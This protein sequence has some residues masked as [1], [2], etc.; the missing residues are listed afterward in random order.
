VMLNVTII[1]A[2]ETIMVKND[3]L[4]STIQNGL[5]YTFFK[6]STFIT[7]PIEFM[8]QTYEKFGFNNPSMLGNYSVMNDSIYLFPRL[9]QLYL[10]EDYFVEMEY[11][12]S[13]TSKFVLIGQMSYTDPQTGFSLL[14]EICFDEF[15]FLIHRKT[16]PGIEISLTLNQIRFRIPFISNQVFQINTNQ[17]VKSILFSANVQEYLPYSEKSKYSYI[18]FLNSR[19]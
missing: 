16:D 14:S 2:Q 1:C 19:N 18:E 9:E 15:E 12:D 10:L 11:S 17:N 4:F 3:T 5:R 8:D 7:S 13:T 6:D